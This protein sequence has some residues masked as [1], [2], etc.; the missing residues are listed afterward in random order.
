[1]MKDRIL[2]LMARENLSVEQFCKKTGIPQSQMTH[3][4]TGRNKP[5]LDMIIKIIEA[6]SLSETECKEFLWKPKDNTEKSDTT[7]RKIEL[8]CD[9]EKPV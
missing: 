4:I 1:M 6:L 9:G 2:K 7:H 8:E 5:S 3:V